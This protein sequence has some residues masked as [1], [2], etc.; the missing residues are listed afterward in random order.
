MRFKTFDP[1]EGIIKKL[2]GDLDTMRA[3]N[4]NLQNRLDKAEH[5]LYRVREDAK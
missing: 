4:S 3:C 5:K 2:E 1:E